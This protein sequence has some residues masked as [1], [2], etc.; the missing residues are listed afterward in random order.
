MELLIEIGKTFGILAMIIGALM[1]FIK[2]LFDRMTSIFERQEA[3]HKDERRELVEV[4][5][6]NSG[7]INNMRIV[8]ESMKDVISGCSKINNIEETLIKMKRES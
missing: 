5:K 2:Y 7:I 3:S 1:Y 8:L 6:E 4:L